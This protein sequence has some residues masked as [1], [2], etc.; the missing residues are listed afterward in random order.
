LFKKTTI[1]S[2]IKYGELF[3]MT[4]NIFESIGNEKFFSIL[5]RQNK[6]LYWEIVLELHKEIISVYDR[7]VSKPRAKEIAED[8]IACHNQNETENIAT[9]P[10][11]ILNNLMETGWLNSAYDGEEGV[12]FLYLTQ[13]ATNFI[14]FMR[15]NQKNN[16]VCQTNNYIPI[17]L[18]ITDDLLSQRTDADVYRYPYR[19]GLLRIQSFLD[20]SIHTLGNVEQK[21]KNNISEIL[22]MTNMQELIDRL[23][24][25]VHDLQDGYLHS[26]YKN[27]YITESQ[28]QKV[29]DMLMFIEHNADAKERVRQDLK[30]KHLIAGAN[31]SDSE[32]DKELLATIRDIEQKIR[33]IYPTYQKKINET[34][35]EVVLRAMTKMNVLAAGNS[36][37]LSII[38]KIIDDLNALDENS[39]IDF[40]DMFAC[41]FNMNRLMVLDNDGIYV[42]K[43][44]VQI[45]NIEPAVQAQIE[46]DFNID[47]ALN[48]SVSSVKDANKYAMALLR[49]RD[50]VSVCDLENDVNIVEQLEM[51]CCFAENHD[52]QYEIYLTGEKT[53]KNGCEMDTFVIRRI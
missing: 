24:A 16:D 23:N 50:E 9:E 49:D 39:E 43:E 21:T 20:D 44:R 29:L 34:K 27:F 40:Q 6:S 41:V 28:K 11:E 15:D 31:K 4:T 35:R 37:Y 10:N 48:S 53:V 1:I 32:L 5:S 3:E 33:V 25:Y 45:E 52:A 36:S 26:V 18:T 47:A 19:D 13:F 12:D 17:I 2:V 8:I 14:K 7:R 38:D 42:K 46:E 30:G 22:C 51:L